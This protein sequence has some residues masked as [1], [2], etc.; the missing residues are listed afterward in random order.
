[1]I[2]GP[3]VVGEQVG[4]HYVQIAQAVLRGRCGLRGANGGEQQRIEE[5][6][7]EQGA[8]ARMTRSRVDAAQ[9]ISGGTAAD[10]ATAC[11]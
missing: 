2:L 8:H 4:R 6:G 1:M 5:G 7:E 11:V 3:G 10:H 9:A